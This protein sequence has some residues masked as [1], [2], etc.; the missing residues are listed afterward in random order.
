[1]IGWGGEVV[2]SEADG[3]RKFDSDGWD[4]SGHFLEEGFGRASYLK[5][6]QVVDDCSNLIAPKDIGTF[7]ERSD[8]YGLQTGKN[9]NSGSLL[10]LWRQAVA[11]FPTALGSFSHPPAVRR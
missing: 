3:G 11:G 9:G 4:R 1:M 7:T 5:S 8:C 10:L 6:I 2:K